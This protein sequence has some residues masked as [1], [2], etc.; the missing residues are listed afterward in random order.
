MKGPVEDIFCSFG[1]YFC[2][3]AVAVFVTISFVDVVGFVVLLYLISM[4]STKCT[5]IKRCFGYHDVL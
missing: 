1:F 2:F 4:V 5:L 3:A